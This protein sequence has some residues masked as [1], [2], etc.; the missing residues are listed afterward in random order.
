M[1]LVRALRLASMAP[2]AAAWGC[3]AGT[4]ESGGDR[5][6]LTVF[7]ASSLTEAFQEAAQRFEE[8]HPDVEVTT[9][10]AG[11]QALR[12]QIEHGAEADVFA[13]ANMDHVRALA[14]AGLAADPR[15]FATNELAVVVPPDNPARIESFGDLPRAERLVLGADAV[16]VGAYAREVL[17]RATVLYGAGFDAAALGRVVS[18]ESSARL[19]RA[20]VELGEADAAIVYRSDAV[21]AGAAWTTGDAQA[22]G[23][24][25]TAGELPARLGS[26]TRVLAIPA[27]PSLGV[28]A[29]YAI[30]AVVGAA[31]R[32]DVE[33]WIGFVLSPEV[34][35]V[36]ARRGFAPGRA[37]ESP[38]TA[39]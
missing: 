9:A 12:L 32:R 29:E 4:P 22:A 10:F 16:P 13:S 34:R 15:V 27:P 23:D 36:L 2:A 3:G 30:A 5:R 11:S 1:T 6:A 7:A 19:A 25:Q 14:E 8:L 35:G 20:K 24:A 26:G 38:G 39:H 18:H 28:R 37:A 21:A 31:D 33:A 17:A